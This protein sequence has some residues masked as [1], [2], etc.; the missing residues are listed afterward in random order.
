MNQTDAARALG[1]TDNH[2]AIMKIT[3]PVKFRVMRMLGKGNLYTGYEVFCDNATTLRN[4]LSDMFYELKEEKKLSTFFRDTK[5][6]NPYSSANSMITA[7][8]FNAFSC[9]T[10]DIKI[11]SVKNIKT[12][13]KL[14]KEWKYDQKAAA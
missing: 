10:K 9:S 12:L 6:K 8:N 3:S 7:I 14:Y 11:S 5:D 1:R 4:C 13:L 2:F